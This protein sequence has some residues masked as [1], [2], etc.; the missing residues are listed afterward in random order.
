VTPEAP[1]NEFRLT[2]REPRDVIDSAV[3]EFHP[4][5]STTP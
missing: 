1:H 2:K 5:A 3:M 4:A